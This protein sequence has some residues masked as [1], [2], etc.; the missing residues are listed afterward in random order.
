[1]LIRR[2]VNGGELLV[3]KLIGG[4]C[5]YTMRKGLSEGYDGHECSGYDYRTTDK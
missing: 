1:V 2:D 5:F 3:F 4:T